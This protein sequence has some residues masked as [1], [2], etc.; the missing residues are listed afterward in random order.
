MSTVDQDPFTALLNDLYLL[1]EQARAR[2]DS[3]V[4]D[5]FLPDYWYGVATGYQDCAERLEAL[6][7]A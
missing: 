5:R 7:R 6:L 3:Y 2:G 4:S 1:I